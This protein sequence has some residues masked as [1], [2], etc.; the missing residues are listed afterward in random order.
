MIATGAAP[1]VSLAL[2]VHNGA[3]YIGHAIQSVLAQSY[4]GFELIVTDNASSDHTGLICRDYAARDDR[5]RY[6]RHERNLGAAVNFN[7]GFSLATGEYFKWCAHDDMISPN[8]LAACVRA[9]DADAG[10]V[11]AHGRQQGIDENGREIAW[12]SG[13]ISDISGIDCPLQRFGLV[14]AT[15]G[16]D[17]AVFGLIRRDA[18]ARTSLHRKYYGSDIALLAELALLGRFAKVEDA[19]FYNREHSQRSINAT[20]KRARQLWHDTG[21][22]RYRGLEHL[23]LLA[24]LTAVAW[25][26]RAMTPLYRTM[27]PLLRWALTPRQLARYGLELIGIASPALRVRLR[28]RGQGLLRAGLRHRETADGSGRSRSLIGS[29]DDRNG[30]Q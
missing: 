24:H 18:L 3:D 9:L 7:R 13:D 22:R 10:A 27:P 29:R 26:Q 2:P 15:Q 8:F 17:A 6:Y 21:A 19:V 5:I 11:L 16:F 4:R 28:R 25:R 23:N 1:R 30:F 20:D 12:Q 14:F